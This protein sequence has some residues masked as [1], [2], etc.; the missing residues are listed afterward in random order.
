MRIS[1]Y[2][3]VK[4]RDPPQLGLKRI[5]A[6]D[7]LRDGDVGKI[8]ANDGQETET[9]MCGLSPAQ[10]EPVQ[11]RSGMEAFRLK[12]RHEIEF[13]E[14]QNHHLDGNGLRNRIAALKCLL[15]QGE[16]FKGA[17]PAK[18]YRNMMPAD[19]RRFRRIAGRKC[20]WNTY[21]INNWSRHAGSEEL[22]YYEG[23][24]LSEGVPIL[25]QHAWI[26]T[27][28]NFVIDITSECN[29]RSLARQGVGKGQS[30]ASHLARFEYFGVQYPGD[31]VTEYLE[32]HGCTSCPWLVYHFTGE[33]DPAAKW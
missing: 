7:S 6:M 19:E 28:E 16:Y 27:P 11:P 9:A 13:H 32:A 17:I 33:V 30:I 26:V 3:G 25:H 2:N 31:R 15:E 14:S 20:Y 23:Y 22:K 4:A 10:L 21:W 1:S 29:K 5:E 12:I 8:N 24:F 18:S